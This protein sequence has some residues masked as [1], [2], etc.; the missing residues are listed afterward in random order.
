MKKDSVTNHY[1]E[2]KYKLYKSRA[3]VYFV[4]LFILLVSC[5]FLS[6]KVINKESVAPIEYS[7][8]VTPDYRVYLKKDGFYTEEY[9]P[10]GKSYVSSAID[11]ID[12]STSYKFNISEIS[13]VSFEYKIIGELVIEDNNTKK[14]LLRKEYS[15]LDTKTK[16]MKNSS[17]LAVNEKF[18]IDYA[19][20]NKFANQYRSYYGVDT[21]SYLKVIFNVKRNTSADYKYRLKNGETVN[22][23]EQ[24]IN[25]EEL[26]IPLSEK[27]IDIKIDSNNNSVKNKV[28]FGDTNNINYIIVG[29][30]AILLIISICIIRII[31]VSLSKMSKKRSEYD[32][33]VKKILKEYDRL[34]VET[35]TVLNT[36]ELNKIKVSKF[37]ELLDVRDN[38]KLPINYYCIKEHTT[39][40]FYIKNNDDMY[41]LLLDID[42]I[43]E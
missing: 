26:V 29:I 8:G 11:Y 42:D 22:G 43:E 18:R 1:S 10:K 14:E 34:I 4:F 33:Y 37:S 16:D 40:M 17:E 39:G 32:K 3:I 6:F 30:L 19:E 15:I 38:L 31:V 36:K 12:A 23:V 27:T 9:L 7:D 28:E 2:K 35:R 24:G 41:V 5:A 13:N 25:F 21:N 20:Y